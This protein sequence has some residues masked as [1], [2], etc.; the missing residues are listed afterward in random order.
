MNKLLEELQERLS[1]NEE[2]NIYL[3]NKN[4]YLG[5]IYYYG[6]EILSIHNENSK[7]VLRIKKI[8]DLPN[9]EPKHYGILIKLPRR[10]KGGKRIYVYK[11]RTMEPY[12]EYLQD[13][14]IKHNGLNGDGTIHK[15][16]RITKWGRFFRK[17]WLDELPMLLNFLNGNLKLMGVRPLSDSM[18][19]NY[20]EDF[21]EFRNIFKPGLIPPYYI[22]SP[23]TFDEIIESERRYLNKYN[24]NPILTD[25]IYF[26]KF[27][28]VVFLKGVRSS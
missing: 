7:I 6:F 8:K 25:I 16:F 5:M 21:V 12:S 13:F 26:F 23:K 10:G 18:L 4:I 1:I 17:Y 27:L 9:L 2:K 24:K 15:D 28:K 19:S 22:D 3:V 14:V 20:P 11:L